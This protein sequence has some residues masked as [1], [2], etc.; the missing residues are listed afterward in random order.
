[1]TM[2]VGGAATVAPNPGFAAPLGSSAPVDP[3]LPAPCA[4]AIT[5]LYQLA[6]KANQAQGEQSKREVE[7]NFA[8]KAQAQKEIKEA[9]ERA[10]KA[11]EEQSRFFDSIGVAGLVGILA[12]QPMV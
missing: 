3:L 10:A 4:D 1:M 9:L 12:A 6:A 2:S 11:Q 5:A 8:A 7:S